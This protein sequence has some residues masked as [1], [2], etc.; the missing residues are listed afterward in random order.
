M[1]FGEAISHNIRN[2]FR[3]AGRDPRSSFWWFVL[4]VFLGS[5]VAN[6]IDGIFWLFRA[7]SVLARL[8]QPEEFFAMFV[9]NPWIY[10]LFAPVSL[11]WMLVTLVPLFSCG[12][13]RRHDCDKSGTGFVLACLVAL[14]ASVVALVYMF[15]FF[16]IFADY[17]LASAQNP[18]ASGSP[19]DDPETFAM[20]TR[21]MGIVSILSLLQFAA[22]IVILI[23]MATKGTAGPNRYGDD[24]LAALPPDIPV[25]S[26]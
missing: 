24:P 22:G 4:F 26:I 9:G 21:F 5:I 17:I 13:R 18:G 1:T 8:E 2:M 11:I 23:M 3:F 14:A 7:E 10:F 25:Q 16:S 6:M 15:Q 20:V 12:I 19:F